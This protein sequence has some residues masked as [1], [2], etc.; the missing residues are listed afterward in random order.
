METQIWDKESIQALLRSSDEAVKKAILA[1]YAL[2]TADEKAS[3][4]AKVL[5]GAGF[6]KHD[7]PFL[8]DIARKLPLYSMNMTPRQMSRARPMVMKYWRQLAEIANSRARQS[9]VDPVVAH[10]AL[11]GAN[12]PNFGRF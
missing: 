6:N 8:S 4:N 11:T 2:Q 9:S 10:Q 3:R 12:H 1:L 5:N 7:A